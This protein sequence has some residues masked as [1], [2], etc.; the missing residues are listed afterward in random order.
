[1]HFYPTSAA[2]REDIALAIVKSKGY[3][4]EIVDTSRLNTIFADA[5]DIAPEKAKYVLIAYEQGFV[6]GSQ[7]GSKLLFRPKD[8]LTRAEAAQILFNGFF[9]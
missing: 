2:K 1:M 4:D 7:D 9:K 8:G 5:S 3:Q 6:K